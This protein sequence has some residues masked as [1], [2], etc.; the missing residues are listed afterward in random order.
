[1]LSIMLRLSQQEKLSRPYAQSGI[2]YSCVRARAQLISEARPRLWMSED[3]DADEVASSDPLAALLARPNPIMGRI[4]FWRAISQHFDLAGGTFLFLTSGK[5]DAP[6]RP[7]EMP[8]AL[9]PVREDQVSIDFEGSTPRVYWFVAGGER[10]EFP[11]HAVAHIYDADPDNPLRGIGPM[12]AAFRS[13]NNLFKAE[14]FDDALVENGGQIGGIIS[15]KD[16]EKSF[17]REQAKVLGDSMNQEMLEPKN[18]GKWA[19]VPR[20]V[21]F[22][23]TA[24]SP[25]DMQAKDLRI[26]GRDHVMMIFGLT[27]PLLGIVADVNRANGRE[28][29]RVFYESHGIPQ[30]EFIADE[31]NAQ[32]L[33]RIGYEG[34][35]VFGFDTSG[36][37]AMREEA[38][39]VQARV[40][41]WMEVGRSFREAAA[42]EQLETDFDNME[43][44]DDRYRSGALVPIS[45]EEADRLATQ[46]ELEPDEEKYLTRSTRSERV[47]AIAEVE[48]R[49]APQDRKMHR[50]IARVFRQ[51]VAEQIKKLE[52]IANTPQI[53]DVRAWDWFPTLSAAQWEWASSLDT[54]PARTWIKVRGISR[55]ELDE[56]LV[57]A[58][59][60]WRDQLWNAI[61]KPLTTTIEE[62]AQGAAQQ[63]E[64]LIQL[65]A[66]DPELLRFIGQKEILLKEGPMSVVA[67]QVKRTL[68]E[69]LAEGPAI[70]SL[71]SR[72]LKVLEDLKDDLA[73]LQDRL[74]ARALMIARTETASA[75]NAAR[76]RQFEVAGVVQH[77]WA[78]AGDD[79]VRDGHAIDGEVVRIGDPF[80]NGLRWP[81]D[82][83]GPPG[84]TINCR[85]VALAV[86]PELAE[87]T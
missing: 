87:T 6:I 38:E 66:T 58:D 50:G 62:A 17:T 21:T 70:G 1:M 29:R 19:V 23:K 72:I 7:G 14:S 33:P 37:A 45:G 22:E 60:R 52:S 47:E 31:F 16:S 55:E 49:L 39:A 5:T 85:C 59:E 68:L 46:F 48:R 41:G 10:I 34:R 64:S 25:V 42:L 56:I 40:R 83:Q 77:E 84:M 9:W 28:A 86:I 2:V 73:V 74:G 57:Q 71:R 82:P 51:F 63:I 67:E 36:I 80:S 53:Q 81:G 18:S 26:L 27:P 32:L 54:I 12:Q 24:F 20:G 75:S 11:D 79:L 4:K 69:S 30:L 78:S 13:A 76:V 3:E 44:V 43:G 61:R 65:D 8:G 35:A 15:P